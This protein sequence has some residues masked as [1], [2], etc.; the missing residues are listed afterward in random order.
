MV[1]LNFVLLINTTTTYF[2][3]CKIDNFIFNRY[4]FLNECP[5]Y[6]NECLYISMNGFLP[7]FKSLLIPEK[8]DGEWQY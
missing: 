3:Y 6:I 1:A 7:L 5:I 2:N 4:L 8:R